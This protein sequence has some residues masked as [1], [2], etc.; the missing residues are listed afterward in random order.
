MTLEW[1]HYATWLMNVE[2]LDVFD[3]LSRVSRLYAKQYHKEFEIEKSQ[4]IMKFIKYT[5]EGD[6][7]CL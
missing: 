5:E 4:E 7:Q 1:Q 3:A 6:Q 2:G